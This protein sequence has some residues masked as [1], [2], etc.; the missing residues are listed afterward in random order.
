MEPKV[1]I[2]SSPTDAG[3]SYWD[4]RTGAEHLRYKSCAS[5]PHSLTSVA[6]H[7]L[8]SSQ[9]RDAKSSTSGSILYWLW[10]KPEIEVRSFL[11]E[12]IRPIACN[13]QGT[14]IVGG[15]IFGD[16]YFWEVANGK[17]LKKWHAHYMA[18]SCLAFIDPATF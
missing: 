6:D 1:L 8:T 15:G 14:Y 12:A 13:S 3:I 18:V 11:A 2:T 7:F 5:P 16:I 4:L 17:L 10:N 9:V